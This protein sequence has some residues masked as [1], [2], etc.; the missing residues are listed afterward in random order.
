MPFATSI[1]KNFPATSH[2]RPTSASQPG[3]SNHDSMDAHFNEIQVPQ[4]DANTI[5]A[6]LTNI[7]NY[8]RFE[9]E[10]LQATPVRHGPIHDFL[11]PP[12]QRSFLHD[13][14]VQIDNGEE[15]FICKEPFANQSE[16][17]IG[18]PPVG[19]DSEPRACRP[20][21]LRPC[22]HIVG[23]RCFELWM[24]SPV[25]SEAGL[26]PYCRQL[27]H[28]GPD[29]QHMLMK[30]LKKVKWYFASSHFSTMPDRMVDNL[31]VPRMQL[32]RRPLNA[33]Q[34][35]ESGVPLLNLA[36]MLYQYSRLIRGPL[37]TIF[38][39]RTMLDK[40]P[41]VLTILT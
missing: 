38:S 10:A 14:G 41:A 3:V 6:N 30:G 17:H 18:G 36:S 28:I 20:L 12:E 32:S 19:P 26:C 15:C 35:L 13:S 33:L 24:S 4:A 1:H 22:G 29:S 23:D 34:I 21:Y 11:F 27:L 8:L 25:N 40:I 37:A 9:V 16:P 7:R 31:R 39:K 5:V 2:T